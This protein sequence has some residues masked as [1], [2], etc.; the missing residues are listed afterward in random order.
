MTEILI[1]DLKNII[2]DLINTPVLI[3]KLDELR[4]QY[5]EITEKLENIDIN[6]D[7]SL[8]ETLKDQRLKLENPLKN[9]INYKNTIILIKEC[10][11]TIS[12]SK[13]NEITTIAKKKLKE[14]LRLKTIL[15]ESLIR[16]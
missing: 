10:K 15:E 4:I 12:K 3:D 5:A 11:D 7:S 2:S 6:K 1:K 13:N 8:F 9:F 16:L 14:S